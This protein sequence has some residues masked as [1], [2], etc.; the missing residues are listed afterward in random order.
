MAELIVVDD[1][2]SD[3]SFDWMESFAAT[4]PNRITLLR[5]GPNQRGACEARNIG[6]ERASG[7]Y[8]KFLDSDD[9]LLPG[10]LDAQ[11][12]QIKKTGESTNVYG[13]VVW[14]NE[15]G[16]KTEFQPE[17]LSFKNEAEQIILNAPLTSAPLHRTKDVRLVGG[18]DP[19]VP[20]GQEH[21]LHVRMWLADVK[22]VYH[23]GPVY[24]YRQHDGPRISSYDGRD[25][26]AR[27]RLESLLRHVELAR[28]KFGTPLSDELTVAFAT[29]LWRNG[30]RALQTGASSV[31][32]DYFA[33]AKQL[34][35]R[36]AVFGSRVYRLISGILGPLNAERLNAPTFFS[37]TKTDG[38]RRKHRLEN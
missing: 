6:L 5:C 14:V 34:A 28:E 32:R 21:D 25:V 37:A 13:D 36:R 30:R 24:C 7:K 11:L 22:F 19:R 27:G 1:H 18:F 29:N 20:R 16:N 2:S 8:I 38:S 9:Y 3:G 26:V 23:S 10:S 31:A 4:Y 15:H 35:G 12:T 33:A 17:S